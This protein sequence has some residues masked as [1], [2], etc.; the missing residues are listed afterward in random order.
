MVALI[1]TIE[2]VNCCTGKI[3]GRKSARRI[4]LMC[5][6]RVP[7]SHEKVKRPTKSPRRILGLCLRRRTYYSEIEDIAAYCYKD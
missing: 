4:I 7:V 1:N 3:D 6:L 2:T 5:T